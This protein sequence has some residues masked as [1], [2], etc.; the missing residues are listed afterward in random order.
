MGFLR[1]LFRGTGSPKV[2]SEP[3]SAD[4]L[5]ELTGVLDQR[6]PGNCGNIYFA[7]F[8]DSASASSS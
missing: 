6:W 7:V 2:G 3:L 5:P 8:S 4:K 1:N